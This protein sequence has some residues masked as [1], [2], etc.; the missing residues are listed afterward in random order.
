MAD[1]KRIIHLIVR[2]PL[3]FPVAGVVATIGPLRT[4]TNAAGIARLEV[5]EETGAVALSVTLRGA[6]LS[7]AGQPPRADNLFVAVPGDVARVDVLARW[8]FRFTRIAG[9]QNPVLRA[10]FFPYRLTMLHRFLYIDELCMKGRLFMTADGAESLAHTEAEIAKSFVELK[11]LKSTA[12]T[13]DRPL[14]WEGTD[15]KKYGKHTLAAKVALN[16]FRIAEG[17][18]PLPETDLFQ[19]DFRAAIVYFQTQR[20]DILKVDGLIGVATWRELLYPPGHPDREKISQD[21]KRRTELTELLAAVYESQPTELR[22]R[23][24]RAARFS[25]NLQLKRRQGA[26]H[27]ALLGAIEAVFAQDEQSRPDTRLYPDWVRYVILHTSG[28]IYKNDHLTL[29]DHRG[30]VDALRLAKVKRL[31]NQTTPLAHRQPGSA[32]DGSALDQELAGC[33]SGMLYAWADEVFEQAKANPKD[34]AGLAAAVAR[35]KETGS[36]TDAS[37]SAMKSALRVVES[38]LFTKQLADADIETILE[39][40]LSRAHGPSTTA[41]GTGRFGKATWNRVRFHTALRAE[42]ITEDT[43]IPSVTYADGWKVGGL[44]PVEKEWEETFAQVSRFGMWRPFLER[45]RWPA[46][47]SMV[48]NELSEIGQYARGV[49]HPGGLNDNAFS[50]GRF[51]PLQVSKPA[52]QLKPGDCIFYVRWRAAKDVKDRS[53]AFPESE[54]IARNTKDGTVTVTATSTESIIGKP[55]PPTGKVKF[56]WQLV[57]LQ[58]KPDVA[59]WMPPLGR[60]QTAPMQV[61]EASGRV[62]MPSAETDPN[63]A[64]LVPSVLVTSPTE[65]SGARAVAS[66]YQADQLAKQT[67]EAGGAIQLFASWS[68]ESVVLFWDPVHEFLVMLDAA[69]PIGINIT[70][71]SSLIG[72][73]I[74]TPKAA[75]SPPD[76]TRF[77]DLKSLSGTTNPELA[78]FL[79]NDKTDPYDGTGS[80]K[81]DPP[82]YSP[83]P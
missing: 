35:T 54:V 6:V 75:D 52:N 81:D 20:S 29:Y 48:C 61:S 31:P 55:L 30:L 60:E 25:A 26:S 7:L 82:R 45:T 8:P 62:L 21:L 50:V 67:I 83:I 34:I 46:M 78:N 73:H 70:R 23:A 80:K 40:L 64:K 49:A 38:K 32:A 36:P 68:H 1:A 76:L 77:I 65:V 2:D 10:K 17:L 14:L 19:A 47:L 63:A 37:L 43:Q 72:A 33:D 15:P 18:K 53:N 39:H 42:E 3:R 27:A 59:S 71:Q 12:L 28:M 51:S 66:Q 79:Q 9:W 5:V 56:K 11:S 22:S 74:G 16:V 57:A 13:I 4:T 69:D 41:P 44:P 58:S 24:Q